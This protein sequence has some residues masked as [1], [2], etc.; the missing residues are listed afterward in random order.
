MALLSKYAG[1]WPSVELS[2]GDAIKYLLRETLSLPDSPLGYLR[3]TYGGLGL[4]FVKNI[5]TRA[6]NLLPTSLRIRKA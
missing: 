5:G 1:E 4:G 3:V 6:N 2:K